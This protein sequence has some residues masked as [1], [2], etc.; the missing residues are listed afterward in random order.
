MGKL[1]RLP[2]PRPDLD[3]A[4][5]NERSFDFP[6][7][8]ASVVVE[9]GGYA[10][11]WAREIA[12]RYDPHLYVFEPQD[13]A[14]AKCVAALAPYP[15]A[16]LYAYAL[17]VQDGMFDLGNF[18]TDGCS[19][20]KDAAWCEAVGWAVGRGEMRRVDRVFEALGLESIDLLLMNIEGYEYELLPFMLYQGLVDHIRFLMVQFHLLHTDDATRYALLRED[21]GHSHKVYFDYGTTLVC[22]ERR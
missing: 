18:G 1:I 21:I 15:R 13:W 12:A 11:R 4:A 16:R 22:W 19:F 5:L 8:A 20:V 17:G 9:V 3:I 7:T 10:G 14:F 2:E 6:L